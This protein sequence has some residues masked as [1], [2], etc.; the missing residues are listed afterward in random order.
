MATTWRPLQQHALSYTMLMDLL[1]ADEFGGAVRSKLQRL[2]VPPR[3]TDPKWPWEF[4]LLSMAELSQ[5]MRGLNIPEIT[6]TQSLSSSTRANSLALRL[7]FLV[8]LIPVHLKLS[9]KPLEVLPAVSLGYSLKG[10]A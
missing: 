9:E 10:K 1:P 4:Q 5:A 2:N 6:P 7:C 8:G 3:G